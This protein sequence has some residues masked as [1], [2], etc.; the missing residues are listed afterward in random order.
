MDAPLR[1]GK[2]AAILVRNI[3]ALEDYRKRRVFFD[4]PPSYLWIE[5]T[6]HC[7][8]NCIMCPSGA[9]L[10]HADRGFMDFS[11]FKK[12]VDEIHPSTSAIILAIGGESLL[13]PSLFRM[14]R[15]AAS[16]R[17]KVS[18]NTNAT[19]LDRKRAEGLL[20]SGLS[21]VSFAFDGFN[22]AMYEKARRGADFDKTLQNILGFLHLKK[23]RRLKKPYAVLS[24]LDLGIGTYT[25]DEKETFLKKFEDLVDDIHF[26]EANSWGSLLKDRRDFKFKI[27]KGK[28]VPC[29]RLWS[30]LCIAW[31]GDVMPCTYNMNHDYVVGNVGDASVAELWNSPRLISLRRAMMEGTSLDLSPVCENCTVAGSPK[32]LGIPAGLRASLADSLSNF[33]GYGFEK[34]AV[35]LAN[36]IRRGRFSARPAR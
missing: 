29:G 27:F 22:K 14:I 21:Y 18:L 19:L 26:R 20:D 16:R 31:N 28:T 15:Y 9:G 30:S 24:L 32:I 12:I 1:L 5:P 10:V 25:S 11:L 34:K 7:N 13:H 17:I 33:F 23:E 36:L 8:L 2:K 35:R 4:R 3:K 6:N